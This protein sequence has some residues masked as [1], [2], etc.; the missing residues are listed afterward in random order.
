MNPKS[1]AI[2]ILNDYLYFIGSWL[3]FLVQL[4]LSNL[5]LKAQILVLKFDNWSYQILINLWLILNR[6]VSLPEYRTRILL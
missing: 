6:K 3:H 2:F 5:V 1:H 4:Y